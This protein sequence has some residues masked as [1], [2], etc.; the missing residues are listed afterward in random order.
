MLHL[1]AEFLCIR[2]SQSSTGTGISGE[3]PAFDRW[4][5]VEDALVTM[6][7]LCA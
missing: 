4:I 5:G 3:F 6:L 7:N 1:Q 2:G